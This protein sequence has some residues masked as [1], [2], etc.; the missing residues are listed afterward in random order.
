MKKL[1]CIVSLL[2][3]LFSLAHNAPFT[4]EY[5]F[6]NI[7]D[8]V[9]SNI[10]MENLDFDPKAVFDGA[11]VYVQGDQM[12]RFFSDY[13]PKIR[14]KYVLITH[15]KDRSLPKKFAVWLKS[16]KIIAWLSRNPSLIGYP[17]FYPIPIGVNERIVSTANQ[18]TGTYKVVNEIPCEKEH[19]L[20]LNISTY[21]RIPQRKLVCDLF[22]PLDYCYS[23]ER[24]PFEEYLLD[25]KRSVFVLSPEG[26]GIDCYRTWE[27]I[28]MGAIPIVKSSTLD[29][30]FENLPVLIVKEWQVLDREF[31]L[32]QAE[33]IKNKPFNPEVLYIDYWKNFIGRLIKQ[34]GGGKAEGDTISPYQS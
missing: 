14:H 5:A 11:I 17:K 4:S 9:L 16:P 32:E 33:I 8:F 7:S 30:L 26:R 21:D 3:P 15:G 23:P 20:Y 27:S 31:L 28:L 22:S 24:K 13:H 12:K 34:G 2:V 6:K 10:Q 25:L 29:P 1:I 18:F 19:L